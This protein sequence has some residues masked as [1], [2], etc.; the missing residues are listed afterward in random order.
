VNRNVCI[1]NGAQTCEISGYGLQKA[2]NYLRLDEDFSLL[3]QITDIRVGKPESR[4][5][6]NGSEV[7]EAPRAQI[8]H[9]YD[10]MVTRNQ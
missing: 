9:H 2:V 8:V 3:G 5:V 1:V 6:D 7:F 10:L 4:V